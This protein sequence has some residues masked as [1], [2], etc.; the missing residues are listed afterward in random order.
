MNKQIMNKQIMNKQIMLTT[1]DNPYDPFSQWY[2]WLNYDTIKGYHSCE[3]LASITIVSDQLSDEENFDTIEE[4]INELIRYGALDRD[5]NIV[6]FKK[7]IR[8]SEPT[9]GLRP[10]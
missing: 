1:A 7:V 10:V 3:R 6:E 8:S 2:E 9:I 4:G 5:G